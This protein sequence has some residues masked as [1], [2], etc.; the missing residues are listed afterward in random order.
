[1]RRST[2]VVAPLLV[3]VVVVLAVFSHQSNASLNAIISRLY[4]GDQHAAGDL[5]MLQTAYNISAILN[6]A[7]DLDIRYPSAAYVGD[8]NDFN[9]NLN[10]QYNKV[11][12]VDGTGNTKGA[13]I[14]AV[15][16]LHQ[17]LTPRSL[18]SKDANTYPQPVRN[19]LVHCHSGQSRS[20][21]VAALYLFHEF[22]SQFRTYTDALN[23]VKARRGLSNNLSV[24]EPNLTRLAQQVASDIY[25]LSPFE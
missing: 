11:G 6:V 3:A 4:V 18:L 9:E 25:F 14:A 16:V 12:L 5:H 24:P 1:M 22:P 8:F 2:S 10:F 15:N 21:T 23:Y 7:W 20:V 13:L 19:V 17:L